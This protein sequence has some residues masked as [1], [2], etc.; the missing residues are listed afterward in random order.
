MTTGEAA[1]ELGISER[2]VRA[3]ITDGRLKAER[4]GRD[5]IITERALDAVRERKPGRPRK[6]SK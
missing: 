4:I 3:L 5:W 2:R 6:D 1:V